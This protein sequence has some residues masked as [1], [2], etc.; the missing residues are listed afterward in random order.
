MSSIKIDIGLVKQLV[1]ELYSAVHMELPEINSEEDL[2]K[3]VDSLKSHINKLSENSLVIP[4]KTGTRKGRVL[5]VDDLHLVTYQLKVLF[6]KM[7]FDVVTSLDVEDALTKFSESDFD[8]AILDYFVPS[9][10]DGVYLIKN[11]KKLTLLGKLNTKIIVISSAP[12]K[13]YESIMR[14]YGAHCYV[15]KKTG[16]QKT[17]IKMLQDVF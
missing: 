10:N 4:A 17:I 2:E 3:A 5:V 14:G 7:G 9:E 8:Y 11:I 15:E 12:K 13:Q 1:S 16:W 6:L